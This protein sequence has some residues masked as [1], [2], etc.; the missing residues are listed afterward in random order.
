MVY[1]RVHKLNQGIENGHDKLLN[2]ALFMQQQAKK[3]NF[4]P[5]VID[6]R[7]EK[8]DLVVECEFLYDGVT[9]VDVI[10]NEDLPQLYIDNSLEY[11]IK[12]LFD[13]YYV[14]KSTVPDKDYI[15]KCYFERLR[16][17]MDVSLELIDTQ[18]RDWVHL[19]DAILNGISINGSYYP[20]IYEYIN[21]LEQDKNLHEILMID[22]NYESHHDLIPE[23]IVVNKVEGLNRIAEFKLIDPRGE[24]ETGENSRHYLYDMGKM[25]FGLDCYGLFRKGFLINDFSHF[26]FVADKGNNYTLTF[27]RNSV[28]IQHL[29]ESQKTWW[30]LMQK[31]P[32]EF[33]DNWGK[34]SLQYLFSFAFMYLPDIPCR[35]IDEKNE[36]LALSFYTR[37]MMIMRIFMSKAYGKDPLSLKEVSEVELWPMQGV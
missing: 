5:R 14:A 23:N 29:M 26:Y 17:R 16:R 15:F 37:G 22:Q 9:L 27:N 8:E 33:S 36:M 25:L 18:F 11:V 6:V 21:Y 13:K 3:S 20:G 19:K 30:R 7:Y 32:D 31:L 24:M 2:E 12:Q 1:K 35:I 28:T 10:F 4:Y 34:R